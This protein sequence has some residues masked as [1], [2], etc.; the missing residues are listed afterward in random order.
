MIE[1][2]DIKPIIERLFTE[3]KKNDRG[4]SKAPLQ[5]K[6]CYT[7]IGDIYIYSFLEAYTALVYLME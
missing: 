3:G 1:V 6:V 4:P 5:N 7:K 2:S